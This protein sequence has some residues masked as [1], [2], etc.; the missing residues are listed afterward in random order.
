MN[1]FKP[2]V[3]IK[4]GKPS[5]Y[6]FTEEEIIF[7]EVIENI[8]KFGVKNEI[9][10]DNIVFRNLSEGQMNSINDKIKSSMFFDDGSYDECDEWVRSYSLGYESFRSRS[11]NKDYGDEYEY[12]H[13]ESFKYLHSQIG[14]F[15]E[16]INNKY[17]DYIYL[18]YYVM[19]D[20]E[21][22]DDVNDNNI[23][24]NKQMYDVYVKLLR[25]LK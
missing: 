22:K 17:S 10:N 8:L 16:Y 14:N 11:Y 12:Y 23:S 25:G 7:L 2:V 9:E 4:N 15:F 3:M 24:I 13:E 5:I 21:S 18:Y 20:D 1:K 19:Y 6:A